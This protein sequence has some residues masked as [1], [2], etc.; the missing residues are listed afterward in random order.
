MNDN[1]VAIAAT[2]FFFFMSTIAVLMKKKKKRVR[3]YSVRPINRKRREDGAFATLFR[4][5]QSLEYDSDQF[6]RYTRM[7]PDVFKKLVR[8]VGPS[9]QKHRNII[10]TL[11]PEHRLIMAIQ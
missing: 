4:D 8:L 1:R 3:R 11:S 9:I 7:T 2:G 6:C 5:M 10:T